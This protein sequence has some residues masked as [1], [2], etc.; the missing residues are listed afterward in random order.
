MVK[1]KICGI[2]NLEDARVSVAAGCDALGFLFY[3]KSPRYISV[4]KAKEIIKDI[5]KN[6]IKIGV[7]VNATEKNIKE[8]A[9]ECG[10]DI[11][12]FHGNESPEFCKKFKRYKIIKVFRIKNKS[13]LR[14]VLK[15]K[16][17]AYLFD[18]YS[19]SKLGGTGKK[20][21]WELLDQLGDL[22]QSI[23]LSGGLNAKNVQAAIKAV[24]PQWVDASSSL[25][26][27]PGKKDHKRVKSFIA[28]AKG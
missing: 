13:S 18:T 4:Q 19:S 6:I 24:H 23:F 22:K 16:V 21:T 3:K 1:V 15:Y 2:T 7:F 26:S 9:K 14:D 25:E 17:F 8:V 20:F 5:P 11:L 12:Q 27:L 28:A 10:L